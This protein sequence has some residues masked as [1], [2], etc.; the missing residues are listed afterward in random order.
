MRFKAL[1]TDYDGTLANDGVV[2]PQTISSLEQLRAS[3][4]RLFLVT[5]R[6]VE[7]LRQIFPQCDLFDAVVAEN[8]GVLYDPK[9]RALKALHE[10]PP[11]KLVEDLRGRGVRPLSVGHVLIATREPNEGVVL[12][13]IKV[14]GLELKIVFNKGAVMVLPPG[15]NKAT[16]LATALKEAGLSPK[17]CVG[18]GDAENDHAFLK[19]CGRGVAVQNAIDAL[20]KQADYVTQWP[21]GRGVLE[22]VEGLMANHL[23]DDPRM[24]VMPD[25][26]VP[27]AGSAQ[28]G[29][30]I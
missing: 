27:Q 16:G 8:G 9:H 24:F 13:S 4:F 23:G 26:T 7:E 14:H 15:V 30:G 20:K 6:E 11:E 29:Q 1:A 17:T 18:V 5:G 12:E 25:A 28:E 2:A 19:L 10:P 22:V 21:N 3:G